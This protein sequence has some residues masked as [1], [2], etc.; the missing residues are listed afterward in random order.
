MVDEQ[1]AR[2]PNHSWTSFE[3]Q[4]V[5]HETV[6]IYWCDVISFSQYTSDDQFKIICRLHEL[7]RSS[8]VLAGTPP[9]QWV[10]VPTGDGCAVAF[11]PPADALSPLRLALEI[12]SSI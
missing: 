5:S 6:F 7:L 8:R 4:N 9:D 1:Q 11:I 12:Q 3:I 10:F 2:A